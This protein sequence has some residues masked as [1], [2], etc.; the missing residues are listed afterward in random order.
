[1]SVEVIP[2][3]IKDFS[4][5]QTLLRKLAVEMIERG[6]AKPEL[7]DAVIN[8]EEEYPTGLELKDGVGVAI[9]HA[10]AKYILRPFIAVMRPKKDI[11]FQHMVDRR[12]IQVSIIIF[13][14][15][16]ESGSHIKMIE[17]L[18]TIF[19]NEEY[20]EKLKYIKESHELAEFLKHSLNEHVG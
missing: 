1:M 4:D 7:A 13:L 3:D 14:G 8:R 19:E 15:L 18:A 12:E 11:I 16:N 20:L 2:V 5:R 9:P 10:D 6:Y 17:K